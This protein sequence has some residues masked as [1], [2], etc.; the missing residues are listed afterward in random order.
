[1][2]PIWQNGCRESIWVSSTQWHIPIVFRI[3][4]VDLYVNCI[5]ILTAFFGIKVV[6][7]INRTVLLLSAKVSSSFQ[8][9]EVSIPIVINK[10]L[11]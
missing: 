1:M 5:F 2:S 6:R 9:S 8:I 7:F 3:V 4:Y 10:I 11:S